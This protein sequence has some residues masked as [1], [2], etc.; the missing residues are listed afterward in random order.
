MFLYSVHGAFYVI[1][2]MEPMHCI[3][4]DGQQQAELNRYECH[5]LLRASIIRFVP[6]A[7]T[8]HVVS[9]VHQTSV[10]RAEDGLERTNK[11]MLNES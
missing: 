10:I 11:H 4:M 8:K 2:H 1:R 7:C 5:L 9:V 6:T 3:V